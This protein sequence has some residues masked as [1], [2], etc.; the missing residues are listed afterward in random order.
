M[1]RV[2]NHADRILRADLMPSTTRD[3]IAL[4]TLVLIGIVCGLLY[5]A[6]MGTFGGVRGE[7]LLQVLYSSLKIP[8]LLG[9]TFAVSLPSFFVINT[10]FGLRDDFPR[11]LRA[12]AATQAALT[13]ILLSLAPVTALWYASSA[14]YPGAILFNAVILGLASITAQKVLRTLY[15]P[16]LAKNPRH[17][18]MIVLW[19]VLFAFVGIQTA[20]VLRPFLGDPGLRVQFFRNDAWGN[21]YEHVAQIIW[22]LMR[23]L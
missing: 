2:L 10:L 5:G 9:V 18:W 21:A 22:R 17:R 7:R 16:L 23:R 6:V 20:W 1:S 19:L 3:G 14:N 11:V 13:L 15:R 4:S 12:L 8:L